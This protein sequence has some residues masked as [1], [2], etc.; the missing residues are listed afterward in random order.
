MYLLLAFA[1]DA[2]SWSRPRAF[3]SSTVKEPLCLVQE[4]G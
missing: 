4:A 1:L 3:C 2:V